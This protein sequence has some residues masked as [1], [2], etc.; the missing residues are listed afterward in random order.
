MINHINNFSSG[1]RQKSTS[2]IR[3]VFFL[4]SWLVGLLIL[5]G[6]AFFLWKIFVLE[7]KV[8]QD[9]NFGQGKTV[10][11][12]KESTLLQT[13]K[14]LLSNEKKLLK[15][16]EK[17]RI[18][19]LLLGMGG[20]GHKGKY[21]TDT[22]ILAS[23]NPESYQ[24]ALLSIP[25]DLYV[26]IPD[27]NIHT[28]INAVYAYET[29]N[30]KS[31]ANQPLETLK[32]LIGEITGQK[33]DYYLALDFDG[34][35]KIIDD[36]GGIEAEVAQD[37]FD[38]RY[39]GPNFS[40]ET[41]SLSKGFHH[42]D[43]ETALKY[44][45]VR[46]VAGGDFGRAQRQQN[47]LAAAKNKAFSLETFLNPAKLVSLLNDLGEHIR[48]DI[49]L[50]EIPS[51][52]ELAKN[53]NA[54]QATNKVLD[55]WSED[56]LLASSHVLL[57]GQNAYVLLPRGKNY[58]AVQELAENIFDLKALT[59][60]KEA[61]AKENPSLALLTEKNSLN[62]TL[63][64]LKKM[65]YNQVEIFKDSQQKENLCEEKS[66]LYYQKEKTAKP[67]SLDN[68]AKELEMEIAKLPEELTLEQD[69]LVCLNQ[70]DAQ[71]FS[72]QNEK[73]TDE[74]EELK[75]KSILGENGEILTNQN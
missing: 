57:G 40:Y 31:L 19:V 44:A 32:K 20:E 34:F 17:N 64:T 39:P 69:F 59:R 18:N 60:Q 72:S 14:N 48:T 9:V 71:Y 54:Y 22:I 24:T 74:N 16:S 26:K 52:W 28:K 38:Q 11:G 7:K 12:K 73:E 75:E 56:S 36:L 67:F 62:K 23:I 15:G 41:F 47:V 37:I 66:F 58:S 13:T 46:H 70:K 27:T 1:Y 50:E 8:S 4:S 49:T 43:G 29:E 42:L 61:I 45:R 3:R 25:R 2:K 35:K 55:A 30:G 21:L 65:G 63:Y 53:I 5:L 68:L 51:F 10:M 33:V 6:G